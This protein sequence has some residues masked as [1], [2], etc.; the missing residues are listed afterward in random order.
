MR[1]SCV[2]AIL[3]S[4]FERVYPRNISPSSWTEE[5]PSR[6]KNCLKTGKSVFLR[7]EKGN[8]MSDRQDAAKQKSLTPEEIRQ[9]MPAHLDLGKVGIAELSEEQLES[10]AGGKGVWAQDQILQGEVA[11]LQWEVKNK[12]RLH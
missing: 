12:I 4:S 9:Q 6:Q 5:G 7:E 2:A 10:V 1:F 3:P 11:A 8:E